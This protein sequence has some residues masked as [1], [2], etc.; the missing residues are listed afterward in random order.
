MQRTQ[1]DWQ[2]KYLATPPEFN[3]SANEAHSTYDQFIQLRDTLIFSGKYYNDKKWSVLIVGD[4][5]E[6]IEVMFRNLFRQSYN[7]L[8]QVADQV[9]IW[10]YVQYDSM[11]TSLPPIWPLSC[12][13]VKDW[14][15]RLTYKMEVLPTAQQNKVYTYFDVYRPKEIVEE[16]DPFPYELTEPWG[17][18]VFDWECNTTPLSTS[19][20]DPNGSVPFTL[21][22]L[23]KKVTAFWYIEKNLKKWDLVVLR[24][25]D[26]E[27]GD[28]PIPAWNDLTL[29]S[30]SNYWSIEYLNLPYNI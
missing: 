14:L 12:E 27:R 9:A 25:K 16:G 26:A 20:T 7:N 13:I 3:I 10:P 23:F 4:T 1:Y 15:Y 8:T 30:S 22:K 29:Q 24:A 28:Q 2:H 19:W 5:G 18:A 17:T 11:K 6:T 21:W